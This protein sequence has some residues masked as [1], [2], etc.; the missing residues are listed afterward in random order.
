MRSRI[1]VK[2]KL[3]LVLS[4][5][6]L[7][8]DDS[9][10][11]CVFYISFCMHAYIHTYIHVL[12]YLRYIKFLRCFLYIYHYKHALYKYLE[13]LSVDKHNPVI[14]HVYYISLLRLMHV[15]VYKFKCMKKR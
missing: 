10:E 2:K 7:Q 9:I 13:S 6:K 5:K 1:L 3:F 15:Y 14:V 11:T 4:H 8:C 12:S